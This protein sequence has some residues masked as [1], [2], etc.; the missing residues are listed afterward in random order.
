M[1]RVEFEESAAL[2]ETRAP[3][4]LYDAIPEVALATGISVSSLTSP[5]N[6]LQAVF[7]YLTAQGAGR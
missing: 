1:T 7:E 5:D 4:R 3:D 2:F 6:N